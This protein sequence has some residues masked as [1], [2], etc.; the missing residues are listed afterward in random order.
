MSGFL[1]WQMVIR[2]AGAVLA[3]FLALPAHIVRGRESI[4][5]HSPAP[6]RL[7][8][9]WWA[10]RARAALD[11]HR[12][13]RARVGPVLA[14]P[15]PQHATGLVALAGTPRSGPAPPGWPARRGPGSAS[16]STSRSRLRQQ[17][18][19]ERLAREVS[20][21]ASPRTAT[22]CPRASSTGP[23]AHQDAGR[24]VGAFL[25]SEASGLTGIAAGRRWVTRLGHR[26]PDPARLPHHA[27]PLQRA[28]PPARA[29]P[30]T[31][32]CP[33]RSAVILGV[34]GVSQLIMHPASQ[35]PVPARQS[36]SK[37]GPHG[38]SPPPAAPCLAVLNQHTS[39]PL[40]RPTADPVPT[41]NCGY[42]PGRSGMAYGLQGASKAGITGRA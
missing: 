2:A 31:C 6:P 38:S 20:R 40:R 15:V 39:R 14:G 42:T 22:T 34:T 32:P 24:Q 17:A 8:W 23:T 10:C 35:L 16:P 11:R 25:K 21:P 27:A 13:G 3:R 5:L 29:P 41:P 18:A 7:R 28:R 9:P 33:P 30:A 26:G 36:A 37:A 12:A 19:A 4:G 1:P